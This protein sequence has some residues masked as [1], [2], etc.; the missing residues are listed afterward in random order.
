MRDLKFTCSSILVPSAWAEAAIGNVFYSMLI[1]PLEEIGM[2]IYTQDTTYFIG[3]MII[4]TQDTNYSVGGMV[5]LITP[6]NI[7]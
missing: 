2:I 4:N 6:H 3:G 5:T 1:T 7:W